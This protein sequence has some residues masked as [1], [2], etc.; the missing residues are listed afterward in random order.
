MPINSTINILGT[1]GR[2]GKNSLN[3]VRA[4]QTRLNDFTRPPRSFLK[5]DGK[6]GPATESVIADFQRVVCGSVNPDGRVDPGGKTLTALNNPASEGK[7]LGMSLASPA[8]RP[9]GS[10]PAGVVYPAGLNSQQLA[11][12]D[13]MAKSTKT[14]DERAV[15]AEFL[16][17]TPVSNLKAVLN[18]QGA[19][20]SFAQFG[21][22]AR[23]QRA[24]GSSSQQVAAFLCDATKMKDANGFAKI[25]EAGGKNPRIFQAAKGLGT[26]AGGAAII[27][28]AVE[29]ADH[30]KQKRYGAAAA[31]FYGAFMS[32][33]VPWAAFISAIQGLAF[34][35]APGLKGMPAINYYF[36][37]L[38]AAD[39]VGL[40]KIA[41][42]S[43]VTMIDTVMISY[44]RGQLDTG[45]MELLVDR[46]KNSPAN[47]LVSA[48]E[49]LGDRA[50]DGVT[51]GVKVF[52][53]FVARLRR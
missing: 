13:A 48:G 51:G 11:A 53:A 9:G 52:D 32:V 42:D 45:Q 6:C 39:P 28:C 49:W 20:A 8:P 4:V 1:V 40:G 44:Q 25:L 10:A 29:V 43:L 26:I 31:E 33:A 37:F 17:L 16:K 34:T 50:F 41:V 36:R 14:A 23:E 2:R 47:I 46:M 19:A 7:W 18:V 35:Y 12:L 15:F 24:L 22:V 30:L 38:N 27:L 5:V 21:I 3:D